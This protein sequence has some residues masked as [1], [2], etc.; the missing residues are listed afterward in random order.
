MKLQ[1]GCQ[2][3]YLFVVKLQKDDH[4]YSAKRE[5][6]AV[7]EQRGPPMQREADLSCSLVL[8]KAVFMDGC[9]EANIVTTEC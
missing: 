2:D 5:P 9:E 3:G 1:V 4:L 8:L 6:D 7:V